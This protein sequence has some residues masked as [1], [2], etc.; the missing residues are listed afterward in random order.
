ML[1]S[2]FDWLIHIGQKLIWRTCSAWY[3][4][5]NKSVHLNSFGTGF[6]VLYSSSRAKVKLMSTCAHGTSSY[7]LVNPKAAWRWQQALCFWRI[8]RNGSVRAGNLWRTKTRGSSSARRQ[9]F[10]GST[11]LLTCR[12]FQ[13]FV[14]FSHSHCSHCARILAAVKKQNKKKHNYFKKQHTAAVTSS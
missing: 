11:L 7:I 6:T 13:R 14:F 8:V 4:D 1:V 3:S 12:L 10:R 5:I 9:T 2:L